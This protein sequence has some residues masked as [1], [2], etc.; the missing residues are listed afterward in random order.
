MGTDLRVKANDGSNR[1]KLKID[2]E[3]LWHKFQSTCDLGNFFLMK[4][5]GI[6]NK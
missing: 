1:G 2:Q 5:K 6:E 3:R 4:C